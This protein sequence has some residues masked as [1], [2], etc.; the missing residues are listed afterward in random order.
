M[1]AGAAQLNAFNGTRIEPAL[2]L[3]HSAGAVFADVCSSGGVAE[4]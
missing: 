1:M 4:L 2:R 3:L